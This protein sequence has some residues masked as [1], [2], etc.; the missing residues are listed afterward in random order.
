MIEER[1][2]A[3]FDAFAEAWNA[4]DVARMVDCWTEA[5]TAV[6]PWG[7]YAT[8]RSGV[9]ELLGGEHAGAMRESRYRIEDLRVRPLSDRSVVAECDGIIENA[10]APNGKAYELRHRVDAVLVCDD[11][12][13]RFISLHPSFGRARG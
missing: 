1:I 12:T 3:R 13:W 2:R 8:G 4:H 9:A 11:D 6:D 10:L 7:R 5:G